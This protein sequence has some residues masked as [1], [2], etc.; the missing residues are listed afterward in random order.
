VQA[1]ADVPHDAVGVRVDREALHM[2]GDTECKAGATGSRMV[3]HQVQQCR[4]Q[5]FGSTIFS[6]HAQT[7]T[8]LIIVVNLKRFYY[9]N[10]EVI[11]N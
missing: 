10:L 1:G 2:A 4:N 8:I 9:P 11:A 7:I 6:A 3:R 5:R